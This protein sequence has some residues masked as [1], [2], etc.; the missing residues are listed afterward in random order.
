MW[1]ETS[2]PTE[3][4]SPGSVISCPCIELESILSSMLPYGHSA[5]RLRAI[6]TVMQ[7]WAIDTAMLSRAIDTLMLVLRPG[8][9]SL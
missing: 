2:I 9:L 6:V 1:A 4:M 3:H 8:L 5:A 7:K